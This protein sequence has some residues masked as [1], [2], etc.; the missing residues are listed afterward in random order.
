MRPIGVVGLG[1]VGGT[2]TRAFEEAGQPVRGYD[3]YQG[4]G[5]PED[6]AGCE[7][8]FLCVPTPNGRDGAYRLDEV[9]SALRCLDPYLNAGTIV[10]VKS[11][12]PPG[13]NDRLAAAFPHLVFASVPEFLV[14]DRPL[15]TFTR[16]DRVVVGCRSRAAGA[17]IGELMELV[18]PC[19]PIVFC[20]PAEAEL[21]KL[22]AN[23]MLAAKVTMANELANVCERFGVD[24]ARVQAG[25]GLDRRIG[26]D[27][28]SVTP[29]R[30][31]GGTCL[32]KDL[33][34]LISAARATG[35]VPPVLEEISE[36]NRRI[37][38]DRKLR[39]AS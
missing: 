25:V 7:V 33:T 22:S 23:A 21:I 29:E 14:A 28:L 12:V 15:E 26:P 34:G 38:R 5:A 6:M 8:V 39:S 11:T 16:P 9:W 1:V 17:R 27:H 3:A 10:V 31:F 35:Y 24:W 13:T 37:R 30:G 36:F 32:P 18:A 4:T 19:A 20:R 2:V